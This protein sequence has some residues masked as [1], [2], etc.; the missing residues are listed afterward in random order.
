MNYVSSLQLEKLQVKPVIVR[1][2]HKSQALVLNFSFE[3]QLLVVVLPDRQIKLSGGI[4]CD[5]EPSGL[6]GNLAAQVYQLFP[7]EETVRNWLTGVV[8]S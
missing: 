3:Y 1:A 8:L 7:Q 4:G 2:F 6:A 5:G